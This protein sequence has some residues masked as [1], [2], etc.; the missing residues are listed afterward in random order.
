MDRVSRFLT[1][2]ITLLL[3]L[4]LP[5]PSATAGQGAEIKIGTEGTYRPISFFTSGGELTGFDVELTLAIC[6]RAGLNCVM[7]TMDNDGM[8]PALN[9]KKIDA[10]ASGM[11]ITAKRK[12][13][14][15]FT[16]Q[17]RSSG[18]HF[19]TCAADKFPDTSPE[20]LKGR[21]IGTQTGTTSADY[22]QALYAG[23]DIRLYKTMDEAFQDLAADRLDLVLSQEV[24]AYDFAA[25]PAGSRSC[26]R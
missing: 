13:T 23:S 6:E 21:T 16:D 11:T 7:V 12:K 15:A 19:V 22:F 1:A 4:M 8:V 10:I 25:S 24:P 14:L 5:Q 3:C 2:V 18:K 9:E 26:C 20:A 17:I